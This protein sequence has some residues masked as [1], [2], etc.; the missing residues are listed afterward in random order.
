MNSNTEFEFDIVYSLILILN[1]SQ[2]QLLRI[3]L[4]NFEIPF[5]ILKML[6]YLGSKV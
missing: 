6:N 1:V 2:L 5:Y 3:R 4:V